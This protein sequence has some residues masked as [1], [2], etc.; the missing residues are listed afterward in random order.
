MRDAIID[1]P[2]PSCGV[3]VCLA[4]VG[5]PTSIIERAL[6]R[7]RRPLRSLDAYTS[8]PRSTPSIGACGSSKGI[9]MPLGLWLSD[10]DLS[11]VHAL[12]VEDGGGGPLHWIAVRGGGRWLCDGVTTGGLW[13]WRDRAPASWAVRAAYAVAP[14]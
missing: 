4:V 3:V 13:L 6:I 7:A 11:L 8:R 9:A 12:I 1:S 14:G 2:A 10:H 5:R